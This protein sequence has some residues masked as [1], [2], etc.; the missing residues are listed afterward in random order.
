LWQ[1]INRETQGK[2][3]CHRM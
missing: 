3:A 2:L 1:G